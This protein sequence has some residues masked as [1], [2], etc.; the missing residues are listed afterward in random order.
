MTE[1]LHATI[2]KPRIQSGK[3]LVLA[4]RRENF[5]AAAMQNVPAL[6]M[7]FI[8]EAMKLGAVAETYGA[9]FECDGSVDYMAAIEV[10]STAKLPAGWTSLRLPARTYAV[11]PHR[12]HVSKIGETVAAACQWLASSDRERIR[13]NTN[14]PA[15]LEHYSE[16]F[17]PET[18]MGGMDVWLPVK[19]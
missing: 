16:A 12:A 11:F 15:F 3:P 17:D 4:G 7:R 5:T 18:G 9:V 8:P 6:W 2:D 14:Q 10:P 13:G 1:S 19:G